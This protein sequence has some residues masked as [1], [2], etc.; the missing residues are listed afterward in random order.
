MSSGSHSDGRPELTARAQPGPGPCP[1]GTGTVQYMAA[2]SIRNL[3]ERAAG[4][5]PDHAFVEA[6]RD[7]RVVSY[8]DLAEAVRGWCAVEPRRG[9]GPVL[10]AC[11]D[12]VRFAV[13][14]VGLLAAGRLVAPVAPDDAV[15]LLSYDSRPPGLLVTDDAGVEVAGLRRV[16]VDDVGR[17][18]GTGG[19]DDA[20]S[21]PGRVLL[22]SSGTTGPRKGI[23]LTEEALLATAAAVC[24]A[25]ALRPGDRG[26]NPLPLVHVNAEVVGVLATLTAGA[27]LLL[28][29]RFSRGGFWDRMTARRVTWINAVPAILAILSGPDAPAAPDPAAPRSIRLVRSASSPLPLPVLQRFE[30]RHGI[31]V[32]ETY[33][34]TEAASQI[35]S[36]P[37]DGPRKPGS[38][39]RASHVQLRVVDDARRP[40]GTGRIGRVQIRGAAVIDRYVDGA[41]A[42][43]FE[44]GGW[45]DTGDLGHLDADGDLFLCGRDSDVINRG[46][47]KVF[48]VEVEGVLLEEPA[49]RAAA[50]AGR[51]D[52][53][54]GEVPVAYVTTN[55]PD[56][57]L[58]P[59]LLA[60]CAAGLPRYARPVAVHVVSELPL[61]P[62]GKI[63]RRALVRPGA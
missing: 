9:D 46:G 49:V 23:E 39:G 26:Y 53:V 41:G 30:A 57:D 24:E 1:A 3:V 18:E 59:Q 45:L 63:L 62:T 21:R 43:R 15:P 14:Y 6:A 17:P 22:A 31:P 35:T 47:E 38:V 50:V 5:R 42:D 28:D 58:V 16:L 51:P 19:L 37:S 56:A 54:L 52:P 2:L 60:R 27:T 48:P 40:M 11:A 7:D 25:L 12:P 55:G 33:G 4:E 13:A 20:A 36:N 8:R 29:P 44:P 32:V 34:M 10:L 61:G